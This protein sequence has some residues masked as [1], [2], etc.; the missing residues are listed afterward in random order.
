[1]NQKGDKSEA[2]IAK[3][4]CILEGGNLLYTSPSVCSIHFARRE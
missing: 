3:M 4:C 2:V 1:M